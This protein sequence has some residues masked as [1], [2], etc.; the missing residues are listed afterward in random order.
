MANLISKIKTP[1]NVTYDLQDRISTFG[2]INLLKNTGFQ[3]QFTQN[4]GWDTT[5][6]GTLLASSWGGYNSGVTNASS[7]YHAHLK[8][9]NNEY[10]YEYIKTNS[11]TWLGISQGAI[12]TKMIPGETYIFSWEEYHVSGTNRIGTG[13][14]YY[15]PNATSAAFH[16]GIDQDADVTRELNK[17]QKYT[18]TF[19]APINADWTKNMT[20]YMYGHYNNNG[21]FYMRHPKLELGNKATDWTPAPQDL[22][23]YNG[24]DTIEFFQ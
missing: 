1:N 16:L 10:V 15:L 20:W 17:W 11:E 6:N 2:G 18:Y 12:Q 3:I 7:V 9:F 5:K 24:T 21:T 22:V 23:T 14:Y 13:L 4:E 8:Q 19:I